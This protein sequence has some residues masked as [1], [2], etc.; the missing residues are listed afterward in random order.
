MKKF[1]LLSL[2]LTFALIASAKSEK[3][4]MLWPDGSAMDAF[5]CN[6]SKVDVKSLG[7]QYVITNNGVKQDSTLLQT[8][9]IQAV[10]DHC[11]S[12]GGGV[13]VIPE[14]TF[15][16]GSL[17]FKQGTNLYVKG[18]I[19]GS[20][21]IRDFRLMQTR[22]EGQTL[23]YF[24]ALINADGLDGFC[25][26]GDGACLDWEETP[27]ETGF[28]TQRS[29]IDGNGFNYW[30]EFWYRRM[31][32]KACT[33]LEAMRPRLVYLSNC[34]NVTVQDVNLINSPFW[35]NHLYRCEHVRYLDNF[36]YAPTKGV[37]PPGDTK[38][39][40]APSSDAIDL[41][42]CHDVLVHGC[43]MQVNDDAVV[44]KGGK[45]TWADKDPNNGPVYNVL[46]EKCR[47]G[48]THGCLTLGSES[49][50]DW[51]IVLSNIHINSVNRVLWLKMRPDTPQHYEKIRVDNVSGTCGSFLVIRPWTQFFQQGDRPDMPVSR[52]ENI[53][54][55]NIDVNTDNFFDVG[56]S[57]KYKLQNFTFENCKVR[58][59]KVKSFPLGE[60]TEEAASPSSSGERW[61]EVVEDGNYKVTVTLGSKK[62]AAHTIVRAESRRLMVEC[63]N[64]RKGQ[65]RTY[66]FIVNKR[67]PVI[68]KGTEAAGEKKVSLKT[69]EVD[70]L[71]WD[72]Q[73]TLEFAGSAPAVESV[74]ID[75]DTT[76]TTIFLCGNSTVVDQEEEPWASWGQ[77]I[78]R[79]F[80]DK[81]AIS[82]HAESG[83]SLRSFMASHRL[84]KVLSMLKAGDYVLC[85]FGHNDQKE[86]GAGDGAWYS[87]QYQ[88]KFFVDQVRAAGGI[89][90]LVTPTQRR[91][92]DDATHTMIQET[93]GD[94]PD[95]MREV[96]R[97]EGVPVIEL[98]DM[99]RDFFETLGFEGSKK[100][101][102]H[103]PANT[104]PGQEKALADNT[105]F[106]PYGAY[107]VAKMVVMGMK[108]LKLPIVQ[109]LREDWQ[110]FDPCHP[111]D[112]D[113]FQWYP[114]NKQNMTKPDG[115]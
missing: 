11:A 101:L 25:I 112:P 54:F 91:S 98:H 36:I 47:Y 7:K 38:Q 20:D 15:L 9:A 114:A 69:R 53:T 29:C 109:Y 65:F 58:G 80:S 27:N 73:L 55:R 50:H 37:V 96:A 35:T 103:Y 61:G 14:G 93:H 45:G 60:E 64:T 8:E 89:P 39:H 66:S 87:F 19:K 52:A 68:A 100:A 72:D 26:L 111:D 24:A 95:A 108:Q 84:E 10:I 40:G 78:P 46:V 105:H 2:M 81:V 17:F 34:K 13:V 41:D 23:Q 110:D 22:M 63:C 3:Q 31:Y 92:F 44:L 85:E 83:L 16:S 32:N 75:P 48:K 49:I 88:L 6:T 90:I 106:N 67:S 12:E 30:E 77:M 42:V 28:T 51:N 99:T 76:A 18:R 113:A 56:E 104:F 57:D 70:Y 4:Q 74:S 86:N 107:E 62:R 102:V 79:W 71:N 59:E 82:N 33:N 21:R 5:F 97:R 115:N 1:L 43:Y 94:Y